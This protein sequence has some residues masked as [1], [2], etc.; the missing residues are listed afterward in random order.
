MN[1]VSLFETRT[2]RS[3]WANLIHWNFDSALLRMLCPA[4]RFDVSAKFVN[5]IVKLKRETGSLAPKRQGNPGVG[6]LSP[7]VDWMR[8]QVA[9]KEIKR[10]LSLFIE[11]PLSSLRFQQVRQKFEVLRRH[12][13]DRGQAFRKLGREL[14]SAVPDR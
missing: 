2:G 7:H 4:T 13:F 1:D 5:D 3:L 12:G 10:S 11:K 14:V 8:A 6:K 9:T